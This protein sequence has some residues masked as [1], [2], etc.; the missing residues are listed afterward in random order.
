[1]TDSLH[2]ARDCPRKRFLCFKCGN[3]G[4]RASEC[5]Y[6][7]KDSKLE[8]N[9]VNMMGVTKS[10]LIFKDICFSTSNQTVSALIDTGSDLC[11]MRYDTLMM[12]NLDVQL[13]KER[14]KLVGIGNSTL[15]TIG[16]FS[17]PMQIDGVSLDIAFHVRKR[18]RFKLLIGDRQ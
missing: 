8:K 18:T 7:K 12:L 13:N 16:S 3:E 17:M 14:R 5:K 15:T 11:L 1:M 9:S 2:F 6:I 10:G 4:H